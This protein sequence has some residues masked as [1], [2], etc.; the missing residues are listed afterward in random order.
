M[1]CLSRQV[2][3]VQFLLQC[4][5]TYLLSLFPVNAS[6]IF[7]VAGFLIASYAFIITIFTDSLGLTIETALLAFYVFYLGAHFLPILQSPDRNGFYRILKLVFLP[8]NSITFPEV[9]L[10]DALTSMSKVLKDLG[11]SFVVIFA[12]TQGKVSIDYHDNAM[13]L[14]AIVASLPFW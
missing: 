11:T 7:A 1:L 6:Y 3:S 14:V 13:Y 12:Q 5:M 8:G 2:C 9:L 10:A 4:F